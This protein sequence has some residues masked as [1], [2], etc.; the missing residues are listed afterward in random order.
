MLLFL[1][2]IS[3]GFASAQIRINEVELNPKGRDA[4]YEWVELYSEDEVELADY[5]LMNSDN[6]IYELNVEFQGFYIIEF[7][8]QWLDNDGEKILLKDNAGRMLDETDLIKDSKDDWRSWQ[9]CYESGWVFANSSK[10]QRNNCGEETEGNN[11]SL[12]MEM[13]A[14][15]NNGEEEAEVIRLGGIET[16]D[17]EAQNLKVKEGVLYES[18]TE[19]VKEYAIYGFAL[20]CVVLIILLL[21]ENAKLKR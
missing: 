21:I 9:F 13:S 2:L 4:G 12:D 7:D 5:S 15:R 11:E 19:Y 18:K 16:D 6:K 14:Q 1:I 10:E 3:L 20:L 8:G 17:R